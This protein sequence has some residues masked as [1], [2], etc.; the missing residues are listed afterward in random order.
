[1][2]QVNAVVTDSAGVRARV[3]DAARLDEAED[4]TVVLPDGGR[5]AIPRASLQRQAEQ[6]YLFPARFS[7]FRAAA[8]AKE[9]TTIPVY[10]E[11]L[12]VRKR[13]VETGRVRVKKIVRSRRESVDVPLFGEKVEIERVRINRPVDGP[14]SVREEG[15]TLIIPLLEEVVVTEKRLM[16]R[17]ELHIRK[18]RVPEQKRKQVSVRTEDVVIERAGP[19]VSKKTGRKKGG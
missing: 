8:E 11:T 5:V 6:T 9:T 12:D 3:E 1:M 19:E 10:E 2:E 17:E 7:D 16:L 18:H 4:V 14:V 13:E 15:D